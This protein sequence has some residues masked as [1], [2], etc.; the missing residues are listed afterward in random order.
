MLVRFA[1]VVVMGDGDAVVF[2]LVF[3]QSNV[4]R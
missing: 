3:A 4:K 2:L 1:V